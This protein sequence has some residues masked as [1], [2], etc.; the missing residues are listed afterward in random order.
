MGFGHRVVAR[1]D[2]ELVIVVA[3]GAGLVVGHIQINFDRRVLVIIGVRI[4]V[5]GC[6]VV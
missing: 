3:E 6:A 2:D 5:E 4:G 1:P